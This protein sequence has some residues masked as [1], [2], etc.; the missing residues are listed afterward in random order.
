MLPPI[1]LGPADAAGADHDDAAV[2]SAVGADASGLGI[3]DENRPA[4]GV[5]MLACRLE[6]ARLA[7]PRQC[8]AGNDS[9]EV[10]RRQSCGAHA[11]NRGLMHRG[12]ALL[13]SQANIGRPG[14]PFA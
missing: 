11:L 5:L 7:G 4:V 3:G 12:K 14:G 9:I 13:H 10:T 2:G 1:E 6:L 8:Q